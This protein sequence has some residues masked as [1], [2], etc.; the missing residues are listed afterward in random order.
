MA[1]AATLS[2]P[3]PGSRKAD[4]EGPAFLVRDAEM[5]LIKNKT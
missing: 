1:P 4:A 2:T 5:Q 3:L